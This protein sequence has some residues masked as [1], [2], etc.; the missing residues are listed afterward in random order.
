MKDGEEGGLCVRF[1]YRIEITLSSHQ[2][3]KVFKPLIL[4][5]FHMKSGEVRSIYS[6][7]GQFEEIRKAAAL[8]LKTIHQIEAKG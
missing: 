1:E 5:I 7:I 8:G 2:S 3:K 6:D 4:L